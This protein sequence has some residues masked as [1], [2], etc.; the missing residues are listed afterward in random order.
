MTHA[1]PGDTVTIIL[2]GQ[3]YTA[4]VKDDLT[5]SL[6]LSE[7]QLT[8]LGN[9]DLTLSASVTNAHGNTGSSSLDFTIDAQL[10][11]L[12]I[13]TVAGDDVI[14][15]IEHGQNLIVSGSST[16]L[17]AGSTVTVTINGSNYFATVLADGTGRRRSRPRMC[18]SGRR[19]RSISRQA[20]R[21]PPATR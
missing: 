16:D 6:P 11:G 7:G 3:T 13:D 19:V 5:R 12:R 17:V 2:G 21:I 9:G 14:N 4:T 20:H 8:A 10:H 1:A 18:R 15:I